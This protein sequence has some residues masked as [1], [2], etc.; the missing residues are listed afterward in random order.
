MCESRISVPSH[1]QI[2]AGKKKAESNSPEHIRKIDGVDGQ[3][4]V[5]WSQV[6]LGLITVK[7]NRH[8]H[9]RFN[10]NQKD[11]S[12]QQAWISYY[13]HLFFKL[14]TANSTWSI[15]GLSTRFQTS[16]SYKRFPFLSAMRITL[17]TVPT[18]KTNTVAVLTHIYLLPRIN[19]RMYNSALCP[20]RKHCNINR[21]FFWKSCFQGA[22]S[23]VLWDLF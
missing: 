17:A 7:W 23:S 11:A 20:L 8:V 14:G 3:R 4:E 21:W 1:S 12:A 9:Q 6:L 10:F 22:V 16:C 19:L 2:V 13:S 18:M 15:N 5:C